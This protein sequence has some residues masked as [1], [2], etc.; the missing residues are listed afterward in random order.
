MHFY[1]V[2]VSLTWQSCHSNSS[3][4]FNSFDSIAANSLENGSLIQD[5]KMHRDQLTN[6]INKNVFKGV[7]TIKLMKKINC[8][9]LTNTFWFDVSWLTKPEKLQT[10]DMYYS[11]SVGK[12]IKCLGGDDRHPRFESRQLDLSENTLWMN[13]RIEE[14]KLK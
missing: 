5:R 6:L 13:Y 12:M 10:F 8:Y 2:L 7:N 14:M 3:S 9:H 1:Q 4:S 11:A